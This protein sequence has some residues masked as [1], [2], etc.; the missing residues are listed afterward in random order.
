MEVAV[1]YH[2]TAANVD[3]TQK[4]KPLPLTYAHQCQECPLG[5]VVDNPV[6]NEKISS[7]VYDDLLSD[8]EDEMTAK[9]RHR[10][11]GTGLPSEKNKKKKGGE[12]SATK[13]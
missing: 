1:Q 8:A 6:A 11:H 5:M 3:V 13:H 7:P 12:R 4:S 10:R 2:T 9:L